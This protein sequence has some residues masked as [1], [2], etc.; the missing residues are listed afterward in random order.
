MA[1][2]TCPKCNSHNFEVVEKS[3]SVSNFKLMFVQCLYCGA[4]VGV[5]DYY[6]IG[7]RLDELEKKLDST[8]AGKNI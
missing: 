5:M 2:S 8:I 6:N 7:Q 3:P 1:W 4:V